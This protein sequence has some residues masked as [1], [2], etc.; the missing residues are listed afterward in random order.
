M[1]AKKLLEDLIVQNNPT[2]DQKIIEK[3][4]YLLANL[5]YFRS[6]KEG[7]NVQRAI[8]LYYE[9]IIL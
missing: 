7:D 4:K 3:A 5:L 2:Q 8:D 1:I 9:I 6:A